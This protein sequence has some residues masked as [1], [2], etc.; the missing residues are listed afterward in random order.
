MKTP[1]LLGRGLGLFLGLASIFLALPGRAENIVGAV[2]TMT[3]ALTGNAVLVFNRA[4][5]GTLTPAGSFSTGGLGSGGR[6]PD[7]GLGNATALA[8][9]GE[10]RFLFVVNPGSDD[11]SVFAV[12]QPGLRLV[13]R[14]GAGGRQP[15]SVA[16]FQNLVYVLNAGGS[17]G[18]SDNISGFTFDARGRL[19]ALNNSTQP[20]SADITAPAQIGFSPDG[21]VVIVTEK[22]TSN[23]DTYPLDHTGRPTAHIVTP[24]DAITP[25]GFYTTNGN[26]LFVSDD[27]NDVPN[28]GA[29][30]SFLI[31]DDGHLTLVSSAIP[32]FADFACW[33]VA[34][35]DG[36]FVFLV[37]TGSGTISRYR[38]DRGSAEITLQ[39][40][41]PSPTA[42]TDL[43]FSRDGRFLYALNPDQDGVSSPG[44]NAFFFNHEN[45]NLTPLAGVS[46]LPS[47]VDG[48]VVR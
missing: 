44:I 5:D 38:V 36:R 34:S 46:G 4:A 22:S 8:F 1:I 26:Q 9:S 12:Q 19:T 33:V 25:F 17:V 32:A 21:K 41:F 15:L 20:L 48:L 16:V 43:D 6:E 40:S 28:L 7:F 42:P 45:G 11:L 27:F 37:N 23:I 3:N 14:I 47:S 13:D 24:S 18:D 2:Y 10:D 30:S 35:N 31:G 29:M 39:G